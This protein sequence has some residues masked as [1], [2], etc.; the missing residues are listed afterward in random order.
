MPLFAYLFGCLTRP[1]SWRFA[2]G[3]KPAR[4]DETARVPTTLTANECICMMW[5]I[6]LPLASSDLRRCCLRRQ[7]LPRRLPRTKTPLVGERSHA[8]AERE[9]ERERRFYKF[10]PAKIGRPPEPA[11]QRSP[12][13]LDKA[14]AVTLPHHNAIVEATQNPVKGYPNCPDR[15]KSGPKAGHWPAA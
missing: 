6:L 1:P 5:L 13:F 14:A 10:I 2:S 9:R 8:G 12:G 11:A 15:L 4:G 7:L 3:R